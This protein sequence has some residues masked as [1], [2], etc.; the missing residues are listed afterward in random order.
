MSFGRAGPAAEIA[1]R[2]QVVV[3]ADLTAR[4]PE[5]Q[6]G[7]SVVAGG[8]GRGSQDR[9]SV[10]RPAHYREKEQQKKREQQGEEDEDDPVVPAVVVE[11]APPGI[12]AHPVVKPMRHLIGRELAGWGMASK[13]LVRKTV[14]GTLTVARPGG[15][16]RL[17]FGYARS[18]QP[19]GISR[20]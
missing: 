6:H 8:A 7:E 12:E 4:V 5:A 10:E 15:A 14:H 19:S 20:G 9:R 2:E 17:R 1:V 3:S 18:R 11:T 13:E 16:L